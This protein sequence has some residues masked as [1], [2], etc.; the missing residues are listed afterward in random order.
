MRL[1]LFERRR[2]RAMYAAMQVGRNETE[3]SSKARRRR[4]KR[5]RRRYT[6]VY[7]PSPIGVP[8]HFRMRKRRGPHEGA[9]CPVFPWIRWWWW[10]RPAPPPWRRLPQCVGKKGR[11]SPHSKRTALAPP[12]LLR[13]YAARATNLP[14]PPPPYFHLVRVPL[15]SRSQVAICTFSSSSSMP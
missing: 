3:P 11:A 13:Q 15:G 8:I 4:R 7:V 5:K 9:P 2:R 14:S 12:L 6:Y 10:S 1:S